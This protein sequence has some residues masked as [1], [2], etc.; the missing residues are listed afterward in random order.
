MP[1]ALTSV[2]LAIT[3]ERLIAKLVLNT[4]KICPMVTEISNAKY[5][6]GQ[7]DLEDTFTLYLAEL[8]AVDIRDTVELITG[9]DT[10]AL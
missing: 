3:P 7:D 2:F 4:Y 6:F 1:L 5:E 10:N 9:D 8:M